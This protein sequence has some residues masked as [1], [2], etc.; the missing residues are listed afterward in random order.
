MYIPAWGT[1]FPLS[2]SLWS[3][4]LNIL[5]PRLLSVALTPPFMH[6]NKVPARVVGTATRVPPPS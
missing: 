5:F 1:G 2:M 3:R 6:L 4:C